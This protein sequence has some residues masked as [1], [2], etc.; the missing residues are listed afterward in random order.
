MELRERAKLLAEKTDVYE[1]ILDR[2]QKN[3]DSSSTSKVFDEFFNKE[4]D[5]FPSIGFAYIRLCLPEL[6]NQVI[7]LLPNNRVKAKLK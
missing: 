7:L 5:L 2:C 3:A 4:K 1:I 6:L